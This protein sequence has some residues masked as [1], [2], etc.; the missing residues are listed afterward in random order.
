MRGGARLLL[1]DQVGLGKTV[2]LAMSAKL[3]ALYDEKPV[4]IIVPK[5][6]LYQ[7]QDELKTSVSRMDRTLL[8]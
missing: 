2:Q 8:G 4:L 5:T 1:A 3:I 6:L 7:W